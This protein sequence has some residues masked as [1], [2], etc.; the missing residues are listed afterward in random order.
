MKEHREIIVRLKREH[1]RLRDLLAAID[2]GRWWTKEDPGAN[3]LRFLE[4]RTASI[5]DAINDLS[6]A[7]GHLGEKDLPNTH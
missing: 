4:E 3:K 7:V 2:D 6:R 1:R 5:H